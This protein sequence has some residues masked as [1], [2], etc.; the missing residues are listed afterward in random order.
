MRSGFPRTRL[1]VVISAVGLI[2]CAAWFAT[3]AHN[4]LTAPLTALLIVTAVLAS[5]TLV[6]LDDALF[7]GG[8]LVA[9]VCAIALLGPAG[10]AV[11]ALAG[12]V[13]VISVDRYRLSAFPMNLL[14]GVLPNMV[15][16]A[17]VDSVMAGESGLAYYGGVFGLAWTA[18]ILNGI[19]VT[20]LVA[21][22]RGDR[23]VPRLRSLRRLLA[24]VG[25]NV[26]VAIGAVAV[27]RND[28]FDGVVF[29]VAALLASSFGASA[30]GSALLP[31]PSSTET[32][33]SIGGAVGSA[34]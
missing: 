24:P 25:L 19:V 26:V 3:V 23:L 12:E 30:V 14:G 21:L 32:L 5:L 6:D 34:L 10:A 13:A 7:L 18:V 33:I 11:V 2:G 9:N 31:P 28:G 29:V 4:K 22:E 20:S 15:G 17:A 8:S 27:Y 16:A 1:V